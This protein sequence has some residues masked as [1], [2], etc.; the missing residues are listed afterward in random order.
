MNFVVHVENIL[1]RM[2]KINKDYY[3][4]EKINKLIHGDYSDLKFINHLRGY[5]IFKIEY[6]NDLYCNDEDKDFLNRIL[7]PYYNELKE[8]KEHKYKKYVDIPIANLVEVAG[9]DPNSSVIKI[10]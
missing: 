2:K 9:N 6:M 5:L 3:Q 4:E 8:K 10:Y 1:K 7:K